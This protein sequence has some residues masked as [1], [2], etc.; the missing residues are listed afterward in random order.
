MNLQI[1]MME[2]LVLGHQAPHFLLIF[3]NVT[4]SK[5]EV[6]VWRRRSTHQGPVKGA[7]VRNKSVEV[8]EAE[9]NGNRS[10]I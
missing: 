9:V 10:V 3:L 2:H 6:G 5:L 7:E 8:T 1:R 4:G